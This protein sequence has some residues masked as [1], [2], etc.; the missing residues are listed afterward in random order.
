M[1]KI[2]LKICI[3]LSAV[4]FLLGILTIAFHYERYNFRLAPCSICNIKYSSSLSAQKIKTGHLSVMIADRLWPGPILPASHELLLTDTP[5]HIPL[6]L[7]YT[8][9]N[10]APPII[11]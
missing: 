2:P 9:F 1:K 5:A 10:K 11:S 7:S 3:Y 6:L 8:V 4:F